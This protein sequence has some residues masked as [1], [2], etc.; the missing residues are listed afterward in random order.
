[1]R[2]CHDV[3]LLFPITPAKVFFLFKNLNL[4]GANENI[5]KYKKILIGESK[6]EQK[7]SLEDDSTPENW[8]FL[9]G[10]NVEGQN[11]SKH[12]IDVLMSSN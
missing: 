12:T 5:L 1:M 8:N 2:N 10:N 9:N 4:N 11:H 6:M 3:S 7:Q